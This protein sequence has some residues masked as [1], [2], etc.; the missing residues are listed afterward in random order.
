M[1]DRIAVM[2]DGELVG[3]VENDD[4]RARASGAS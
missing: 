4:A 3:T 2:R 1:S